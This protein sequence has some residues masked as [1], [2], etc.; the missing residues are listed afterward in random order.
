[1]IVKIKYILIIFFLALSHIDAQ[2]VLNEVSNKN[3]TSILDN[4]GDNEDWIELYNPT[5]SIVDITG[6]FITDNKKRPT[7]WSFNNQAISENSHLLIFASGK[8]RNSTPQNYYWRTAIQ[9]SETFKYIV[10][11]DST[12]GDWNSL[13]F[14]DKEW[15]SGQAGFGYGDNDDSTI[16]PEGTIVVYVRKS[17]NFSVTGNF[18]EALLH[19]DYDDGFIAYINGVEVC[20]SGITGTPTWNSLAD[21]NH[22]AYMKDGGLPKSF[23]VNKEVLDSILVEGENVLAIEVHNVGSSSS[24]LSLIPFLSILVSD[25]TL[26]YP[27][28]DWFLQTIN[29]ELHSNFK[30]S[31]KGETIYLF[32]NHKVVQDSLEVDV[33]ELNYSVGRAYD[34]SDSLAQFSKATPGKSNN[35]STPYFNGYEQMPYYSHAAGYYSDSINVFMNSHTSDVNITYTIDGSDPD[36]SSLLYTGNPIKLITTTTIR[37]RS[38]SS[39]NKMPSKIH[40]ATYILNEEYDIPV[41][42]VSTNNEH[43]YGESGI[44]TNWKES[45]NKPCFVEY[46]NTIDTLSFSQFAGIQMDG[47]AGGSRFLDQHS[48]RIEPGNGTFGEGD[49][50]Y[51]LIPDRPER[52]SYSSFYLRN[53]S[54]QHLVLPYKDALEVKAMGKNTHNYYSAYRPVIVLINGKYFGVYELRE[55]I[56]EDYLQRNYNMDTDSIDLLGVSYFKGGDLLANEGTTDQFHADYNK[57]ISMDPK[58]IEYLDEVSEFLDLNNYTDYVIAQSWINNIDWAFNNN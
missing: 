3:F 48:F 29:N 55:K 41:L 51:K 11:S 36:E 53:G 58:S 47:G 49:L 46:F 4:D 20:R 17:F 39:T 6:W 56:N 12:F 34:G 22:E 10:P 24:D 43:L 7:K 19:I 35:I 15:L 33:D 13:A 37:A 25:S 8:D 9:P 16:V 54:N 50:K 40:T 32:N 23:F 28:P 44:F 21:Y 31:S 52:K 1:M 27:V 57:F 38:Y 2:V 26:Y 14:D 45:W 42:S 5:D 18:H 30:I